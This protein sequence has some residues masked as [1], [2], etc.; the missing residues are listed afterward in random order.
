[1]RKGEIMEE[2]APVFVKIEDYKDVADMVSLMRE[3]ISQARFLLDKIKELKAQEDA[4]IATWSRELDD[5]DA[6]VTG[7]DR[8]LAEPQQ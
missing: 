2:R 3:K 6:R 4:E 5:V 1:M 7:V 8:T